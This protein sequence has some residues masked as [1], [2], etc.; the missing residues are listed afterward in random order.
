MWVLGD[1]WREFSPMEMR[2]G[3]FDLLVRLGLCGKMR[4]PGWPKP[5][6][7]MTAEGMRETIRIRDGLEKLIEKARPAQAAARL[8]EVCGG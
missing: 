6:F 7:R 5:R 8:E 1:A 2:T 3:A 4:R